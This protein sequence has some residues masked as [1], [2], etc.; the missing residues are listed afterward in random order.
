MENINQTNHG[1]YYNI[2]NSAKEVLNLFCAIQNTLY[3]TLVH[4]M[5]HQTKV[6]P[7]NILSWL[8]G[9]LMT[10]LT[11]IAISPYFPIFIASFDCPPSTVKG[12]TLGKETWQTWE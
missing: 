3:K 6:Y 8:T 4:Q 11:I 5:A 12:S 7:D 1:Q 9:F 10:C 2:W